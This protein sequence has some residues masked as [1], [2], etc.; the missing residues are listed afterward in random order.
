MKVV[1]TGGA[2]FLGRRLA[3]KLL[4]QG[5]LACPDG[6]TRTIDELVV[7]DAVEPAPFPA[8]DPRVRVLIGSIADGGLMNRLIEPDVDTVFHFA[9]VVSGAAEADFD[10]GMRVNIDGTRALFE[11]C[12][13]LAKPPTVVFTSSVAVFGGAL[14]PVLDDDTPLRPQTSYGMQKAVGELLLNDYTRKGFMDGRALRLPTI[15]VR[16]GKPNK[17]ASSFA[18]GI[19][20]EPLNGEEAVCPVG[21]E[22]RMWLLSPRRVI[23][24]FL[25]AHALPAEAWGSD[26]SLNL[27]GISCTVGEMVEGLRRVAGEEVVKRIRW[28]HDPLIA[29]IVA[30]WPGNFDTPRAKRLGFVGDSSIDEIIKAH[31]EDEVKPAAAA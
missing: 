13:A 20:R 8:T 31:I 19:F 1:I 27:P 3:Q 9:A 11:A 15:S 29:R 12:R 5:S 23:D 26:R 25:R 28:E 14:P 4:D 24:A 7:F 17:A 22:A 30:G 6:Q 18:S 2:G 21:P 16:P 10:L